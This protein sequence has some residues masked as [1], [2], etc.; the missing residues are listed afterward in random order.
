M[1]VCKNRFYG[2]YKREVFHVNHSQCYLRAI[3]STTISKE[4]IKDKVCSMIDEVVEK[5]NNL[6]TSEVCQL[7]N[8]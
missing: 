3:M 8:C 7:N 2:Y 4:M 1:Y 6:E 5:R